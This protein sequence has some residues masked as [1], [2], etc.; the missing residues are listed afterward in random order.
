M[1]FGGFPD[2][3]RNTHTH[4]LSPTLAFSYLRLLLKFASS[5]SSANLIRCRAKVLLRLSHF[6]TPPPW[7]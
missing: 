1:E 7:V 5:S 3:V 4:L 6:E 2:G